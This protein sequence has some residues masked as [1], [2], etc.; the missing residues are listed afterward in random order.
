MTGPNLRKRGV[1]QMLIIYLPAVALNYLWEIAQAPL[2]VG[3][4]G[5]SDIGWHCFVASLGDGVLIGIIDAIGCA[6]FRRVDWYCHPTV[7][8][9]LMMFLTGLLIAVGIEWVA[10]NILDR[11]TYRAAMPIIPGL[12][13]GLVPVAQMLVLP[14]LIFLLAAKWNTCKSVD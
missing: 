2:F 10:I 12:Q 6:T 11:W 5:W 8:T 7:R 9:Y 14:P 3:M 4:N 13:V 1:P